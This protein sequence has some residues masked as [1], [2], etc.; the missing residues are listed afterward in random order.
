M[1]PPRGIDVLKMTRQSYV[2]L[3]SNTTDE[4]SSDEIFDFDDAS[5]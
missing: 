4:K 1:Y 5:G 2:E 3:D